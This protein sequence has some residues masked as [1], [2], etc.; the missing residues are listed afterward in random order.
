M[1]SLVW[2]TNGSYH[3]QCIDHE[4]PGSRC[5]L[6]H[7]VLT[8]EMSLCIEWLS[9]VWVV[10]HQNRC[11]KGGSIWYRL[12]RGYSFLTPICGSDQDV[13]GTWSRYFHQQTTET[14]VNLTQPCRQVK[15]LKESQLGKQN[16]IHLIGNIKWNSN[17]LTGVISEHH[18]AEC[19]SKSVFYHLYARWRI[20]FLTNYLIS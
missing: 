6:I 1:Q 15:R 5:F 11:L 7:G 14:L 3:S 16:G 13:F 2:I 8:N 18:W 10:C 19:G 17:K 12:Q 9:I 20:L 4:S